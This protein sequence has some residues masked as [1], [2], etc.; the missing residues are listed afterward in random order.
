MNA[1]QAASGGANPGTQSGVDYGVDCDVHNAVPRISELFPYLP[2]RWQDYC[3]E[4]GVTGLEPAA[5][6]IRADLSA[7][8][9]SRRAAGPPGSAGDVLAEDV[10]ADPD[11][12]LAIL[13]CLYA[14]QP[15]HNEDWGAA[16][17]RALN[18]WVAARWLAA[19]R[20]FRASIVVTCQNPWLAAE[21]IERLA[22]DASFVQVL[23]LAGTEAPLGKR[24]YWPMYEAAA[25]AGLPIAIH[26]G[27]AG[28]NPPTPIGWPSTLIEDYAAGSLALQAQLTSL[29][30]EGVFQE[31]P[32][33]TFVLLESGVTWLPPL[34]WRLDKNWKGLRREI[35]W[36]DEP[37]S[38]AV[39][40]HVRLSIAPF[41]RPA[42]DPGGWV[43]SFLDQLGSLDMLLYASDYPHWHRH[44]A[45][46]ALLDFLSPDER[47]QVLCDNPRRTYR[48]NDVPDERRPDERPDEQ[49]GRPR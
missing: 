26:P 33:L 10:F 41:D 35:P 38:H 14:V 7:T 37:P 28:G 44:D 16:M 39:R 22:S 46:A 47:R 23:V 31:F 4:H 6:P 8:P 29:I 19:D 36:L 34:L 3:V 42:T 43:R 49:G 32:D 40:R 18:D 11:V 2:E 25:E 30:C 45:R 20:R 17:A 24:I 12:G 9:R 15:I 5:Y 1:R 21:E 27:A 48:M 13:N